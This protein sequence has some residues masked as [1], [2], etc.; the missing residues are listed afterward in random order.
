[1]LVEDGN[2]DDGVNRA[3]GVLLLVA[4][5]VG[6]TGGVSERE[7]KEEGVRELDEDA[8]WVT[9]GDRVMERRGD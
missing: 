3:V 6:V 9:E 1:M 8:L 4:L 7:A 2:P 5:G